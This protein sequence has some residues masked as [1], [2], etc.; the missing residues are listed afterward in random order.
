VADQPRLETIQATGR[1][2][3]KSGGLANDSG[4]FAEGRLL[5]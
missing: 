4:H 3:G 5:E 1:L 2:K